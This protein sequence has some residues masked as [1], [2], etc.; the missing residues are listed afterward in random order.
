MKIILLSF[1]I[2]FSISKPECKFDFTEVNIKN[3]EL[4]TSINDFNFEDKIK[5]K[6]THISNDVFIIEF[7]EETSILSQRKN[8]QYVLRFED[9]LLEGYTF[10]IFVEENKKGTEFYYDLLKQIDKAKNDFIKDEK[11]LSYMKKSE[12]CDRFFRYT[13]REIFGGIHKS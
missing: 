13:G 4:N 3:F 6:K 2:F 5:F 8:V 7:Q 12:N 10:K 9:N 1:L 11:L